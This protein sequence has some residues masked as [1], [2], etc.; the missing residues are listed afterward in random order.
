MKKAAFAAHNYAT[1]LKCFFF[2]RC[3]RIRFFKLDCKLTRLHP[4]LRT[5]SARPYSQ[6]ATETETPR[7]FNRLIAGKYSASPATMITS[8]PAS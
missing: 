4:D 7:P 5:K 1:A 6:N 2:G 8:S 3:S